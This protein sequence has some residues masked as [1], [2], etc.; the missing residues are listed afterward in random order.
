MSNLNNLLNERLKKKQNSSRMSEMALQSV[1]GN[2]SGF[3]GIF[4]VSDLSDKEKSILETLLTRYT[5]NANKIDKDLEALISI[6]SEIKA[7]NNQAALL[8]GERIKQ[9]QTILISYQE[10]AFTAWLLATYGNRQTPYNFLQYYDFCQALP[11]TLKTQIE[12]MPRQ[13][14]YALASR[15]GSLNLKQTI[16]ENYQ[17][18]TKSQ[19]LEK[20]RD[21]FPLDLEDR[22]AENLEEKIFRDLERLTNLLKDKGSSLSVAAKKRLIGLFKDI[23]THLND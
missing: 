19:L 6:T 21:V 3:A 1:Q 15:R 14:V 8:H 20:I 7:I 17:G 18:E 5:Q 23:H 4:S 2:L 22:R 12:K 9:A 11:H 13:A 10:G 16:V